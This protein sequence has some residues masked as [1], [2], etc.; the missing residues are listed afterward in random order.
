VDESL[1]GTARGLEVRT[2]AAGNISTND[3]PMLS[4]ATPG[5]TAPLTY[6]IVSL[7]QSGSLSDGNTLITTVPYVLSSAQVRYTPNLGF[8]G[9]DSFSFSA[10][11]GVT[12][13]SASA[14]IN[15]VLANCALDGG[16]C[17]NGR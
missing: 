1:A 7:P 6:T 3:V 2:T 5:V 11:N 12:A 9:A 15:V 17:D 10:S 8:I 14:H 16:A 13:T 4:L